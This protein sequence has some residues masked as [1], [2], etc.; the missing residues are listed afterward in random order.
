MYIIYH[1][2]LHTFWIDE[3]NYGNVHN[4][5]QTSISGYVF[6]Y[7]LNL[8]NRISDCATGYL[9]SRKEIRPISKVKPT[10]QIDFI[11]ST[12][13]SAP[14]PIQIKSLHYI[15]LYW[16]YVSCKPIGSFEI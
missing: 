7:A 8:D 4:F 5:I 10:N 1:S 13:F 15:L 3:I 6:E 14:P 16:F 11:L 2:Y 12:D 9:D